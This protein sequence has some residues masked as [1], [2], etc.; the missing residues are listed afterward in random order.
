MFPAS[1]HTHTHA[2][3]HAAR[4]LRL[5]LV[6][7]KDWHLICHFCRALAY[8]LGS[9]QTHKIFIEGGET[10]L[11]GEAGGGRG[12]PSAFGSWCAGLI[13]LDGEELLLDTRCS[14]VSALVLILVLIPVT[15]TRCCTCASIAVAMCSNH[16]STLCLFP[17]PPAAWAE[18]CS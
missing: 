12:K 4:C 15:V 16:Y 9:A 8:I 14:A 5:L 13:E 1:P 18:C 10:L 17:L 2:R 3:T 6:W 11:T 7:P